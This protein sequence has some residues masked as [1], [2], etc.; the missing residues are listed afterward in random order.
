MDAVR[1]AVVEELRAKIGLVE[2]LAHRREALPFGVGAVDRLL[3]G[4]GLARGALHEMV[5]A[6]PASEFASCTTSFAAGIAARLKGPVLWCRTRDDLNAPGLARCG[7]GPERVIHALAPGDREVLPLVEEGLKER[8]LAAVV[9]EVTRMGLRESRR[10]QLA[11]EAS[12]VATLVIRRWWT[13]GQRAMSELP[14]AAVTRWRIGPAGSEALPA[15]GLGRARW[16]V[17]LV[18]CKGGCPGTWVLEA[19]DDAGSMSM[20]AGL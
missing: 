11:A 3:P 20:P 9:A 4:G 19:C 17:E 6:G 13:A 1:R 15:P 8:G 12:G 7:L 16:K 18:R 5:E 2:G 10:I 14:T